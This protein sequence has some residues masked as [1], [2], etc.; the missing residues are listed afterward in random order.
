MHWN[1]TDNLSA[2]SEA[3]TVCFSMQDSKIGQSLATAPSLI[4]HIAHSGT[5]WPC[6]VLY[7][8]KKLLKLQAENKQK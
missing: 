8:Q 1:T 7:V 4:D 6:Q 2:M 3:I 5:F